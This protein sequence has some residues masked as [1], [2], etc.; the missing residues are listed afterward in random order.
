MKDQHKEADTLTYA[1]ALE[2]ALKAVKKALGN[3]WDTTN[4]E[5]K[6]FLILKAINVLIV[7]MGYNIIAP[8]NTPKTERKNK[9]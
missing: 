1:Q 9:E 6:E 4:Q 8:A 2:S 5:T 3:E 7:E